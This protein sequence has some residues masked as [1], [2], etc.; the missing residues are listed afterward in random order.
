MGL[1]QSLKNLEKL[2]DVVKQA[3]LLYREFIASQYPKEELKEAQ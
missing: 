1:K 3:V 2:P